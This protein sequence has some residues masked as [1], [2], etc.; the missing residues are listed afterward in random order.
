MLFNQTRL[1]SEPAKSHPIAGVGLGLRSPHINEILTDLPAIPWFELLADNHMVEGGLIAAQLEAISQNYPTTFHSVGLS[2]ASVDPLDMKYL[3]Q[4]KKLMCQHEVAWLSEH[5]CF[6]AANGLHSHDLL[7]IPYSEESL[8]HMVQRISQVQDFLG[9]QILLEN[10][11]SYMSFSSSTIAE[12]DFISAVAE[13]AD[14]LL[15][16][17][18]NNMYVNHIN[19]GTDLDEYL[20]K[21]PYERIKEVHLAG[22]DDRGDYIL[23]AHNNRV[24]KPVWTLYE[25]L[26]KN[27]PD[28]P[29]LIEW[30]NDIPALQVLMAESKKAELIKQ[31]LMG[32]KY[33]V[34]S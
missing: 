8:Q 1:D 11:S 23:D 27:I 26:I 13:Q 28:V 5:C 3:G 32:D 16:I 31:G 15:L 34:A 6:T 4:L 14:C 12:V 29:T 30:D 18:V 33:Y 25:K 21:L 7:P 17:D 2:L 20:T 19:L 10:V 9:E 24:A 22:F